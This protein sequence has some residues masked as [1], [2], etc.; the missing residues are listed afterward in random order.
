ME[1]IPE[2]TF[3]DRVDEF[4]R[5]AASGESFVITTEDRPVAVLSPLAGRSWVARAEV[6]ELL[7]TPTD[8]SVLDD[9]RDEEA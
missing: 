1:T 3:R 6:R 5:R 2:R 9:L 4:V 8:T 7:A